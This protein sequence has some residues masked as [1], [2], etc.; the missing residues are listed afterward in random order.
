VELVYLLLIKTLILIQALIPPAGRTQDETGLTGCDGRKVERQAY[1]ETLSLI[2]YRVETRRFIEPLLIL[3]VNG[4]PDILGLIATDESL[5][6]AEREVAANAILDQLYVAD[7]YFQVCANYYLNIL[8]FAPE[9][10]LRL[11]G[12]IGLA[13]IEQW[14]F[15]SGDREEQRKTPLYELYYAAMREPDPE[16][17]AAMRDLLEGDAAELVGNVALTDKTVGNDSFRR[18]DSIPMPP[19]ME[20][21]ES[22]GQAGTAWRLLRW[23]MDAN[24]RLEAAGQANNEEGEA[25][26]FT[27]MNKAKPQQVQAFLVRFR[28]AIPSEEGFSISHLPLL[29]FFV[30]MALWGGDPY[31][32][33]LALG[34]VAKGPNEQATN[35]LV[36][37]MEHDDA[38]LAR[39]AAADWLKEFSDN[40]EIRQRMI[41]AFRD[42]ADARVKLRI[43]H[44]LVWPFGDRPPPDVQ[45]FLLARLRDQ[46]D[47]KLLGYIVAL[48]GNSRVRSATEPLTELARSTSDPLLRRR[49]EDALRSIRG[50]L[51]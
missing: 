35:F 37:R 39:L 17:R 8:A 30:N 28:I 11:K 9:R 12:A 7:A 2:R 13:T 27:E 26:I 22:A 42:E 38:P 15:L 47:K 16:S 14:C 36:D 19:L 10:S 20:E 23:A 32:R 25:A 33:S 4:D 45:A 31:V 41:A 46:Q 44:S 49:I 5:P 29:E 3:S 51:N 43:L 6:L 50:R 48:L 34:P 21:E 1:E 24:E 40:A 18:F